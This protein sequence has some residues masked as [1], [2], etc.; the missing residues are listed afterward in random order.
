MAPGNLLDI[1]KV[2]VRRDYNLP[3]A[4]LYLSGHTEGEFRLQAT[5]L[6]SVWAGARK[7]SARLSVAWE[8]GLQGE[9]SITAGSQVIQ[10]GRSKVM[11]SLRLQLAQHKDARLTPCP[12]RAR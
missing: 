12:T 10:N 9:A 5:R 4:K 2:R 11:R 8:L 1:V 3:G 7:A 6:R